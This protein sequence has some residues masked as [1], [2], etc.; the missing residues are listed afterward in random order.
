M[1]LRPGT[2]LLHVV[3][4]V[5]RNSQVGGSTRSSWGP[6]ERTSETKVSRVQDVSNIVSQL[7]SGNNEKLTLTDG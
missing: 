2:G 4:L 7:L 6:A 5:T 1:R 3:H